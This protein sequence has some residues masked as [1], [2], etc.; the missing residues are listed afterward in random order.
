MPVQDGTTQGNPQSM[1]YSTFYNAPLIKIVH[2]LFVL[3]PGFINDS[4]VLVI[5]NS[6][7]GCHTIVKDMMEHSGGSF[8]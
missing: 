4:M 3:S 6:L 8:D 2:G 7:T 5:A 1:L